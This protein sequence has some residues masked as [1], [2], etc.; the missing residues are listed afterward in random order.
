[1]SGFG[2]LRDMLEIS[3]SQVFYACRRHSLSRLPCHAESQSAPPFRISQS[4]YA[5]R[6]DA[7]YEMGEVLFKIPPSF[8]GKNNAANRAAGVLLI[9]FGETAGGITQVDS[10][11]L[12]PFHNVSP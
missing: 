2:T 3:P 4:N 6:P 7:G 9:E 5:A 8:L 10:T 12:I 1:M 11:N